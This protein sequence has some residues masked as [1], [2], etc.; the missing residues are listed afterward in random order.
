MIDFNFIIASETLTAL[1]RT[2]A[3]VEDTIKAL[4][5]KA[6]NLSR[7]GVEGGAEEKD[8][9][10]GKGKGKG[11]GKKIGERERMIR[12]ILDGL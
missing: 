1:N 2:P 9:D 6:R 7:A 11:K 5:K 12:E 10:K 8:G 4:E 3:F